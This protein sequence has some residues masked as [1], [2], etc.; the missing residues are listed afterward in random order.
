MK[1]GIL[2]TA[3]TKG[4]FRKSGVIKWKVVLLLKTSYVQINDVNMK[5]KSTK[6]AR[7]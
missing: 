7:D 4:R 2:L 1:A 6:K 5:G 3:R